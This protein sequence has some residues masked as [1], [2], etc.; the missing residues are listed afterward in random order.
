MNA[1]E[2]LLVV[3]DSDNAYEAEEIDLLLILRHPGID[4]WM[5]SLILL[6]YEVERLTCADR[7]QID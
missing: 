7:A 3:L 4:M 2:A 6:E 5:L 1:E